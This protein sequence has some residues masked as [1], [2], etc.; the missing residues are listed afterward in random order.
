MALYRS[1]QARALVHGRDYCV[2]DDIKM[3]AVPVLAHRVVVS[4]KMASPVGEAD[5]AEWI[6][7]DL[8]EKVPVPV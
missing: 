3:L 8:L 2:P 7:R 4:Q 1:A 5:E 6:I